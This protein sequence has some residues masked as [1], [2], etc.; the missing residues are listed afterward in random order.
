MP[1]GGATRRTVPEGAR[2]LVRSAFPN[3]S[4]QPTEGFRNRREI[5]LEDFTLASLHPGGT[6]APRAFCVAGD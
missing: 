1:L 3:R 2:G 6:R 5:F 4:R